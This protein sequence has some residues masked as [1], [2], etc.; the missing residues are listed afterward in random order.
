[1][2]SS[3]DWAALYILKEELYALEAHIHPTK[4][5]KIVIEWLKA[6]IEELEKI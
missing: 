6:R 4:N 1:M 2:K 5:R 3:R